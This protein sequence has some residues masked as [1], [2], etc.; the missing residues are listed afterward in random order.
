V[1]WHALWKPRLTCRSVVIN[2]QNIIKLR[3]CT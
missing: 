3:M 2:A 1:P